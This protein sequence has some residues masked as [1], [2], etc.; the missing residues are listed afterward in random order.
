MLPD[1]K[2][3]L[4]MFATVRVTVDDPVLM[5]LY[6]RPS[7]PLVV[8]K[9]I[10]MLVEAFIGITMELAVDTFSAVVVVMAEIA[11]S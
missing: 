11:A 4:P 1:E 7:L 8:G 2:V 5:N 3:S 6:N 10:V 9:V